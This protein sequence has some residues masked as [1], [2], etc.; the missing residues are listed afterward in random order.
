MRIFNYDPATGEFL[1]EGIADLCPVSKTNWI[2]PAHAT[3]LEPPIVEE[4][5]KACFVNNKWEITPD[6]RGEQ[7]YYL[8]TRLPVI[9]DFIGEIPEGYVKELPIIPITEQEIFSIQL[10]EKINTVNNKLSSVNLLYR[11]I[12][13]GAIEF[14]IKELLSNPTAEMV[15]ETIQVIQY[16]PLPPGLT[17]EQITDINDIK[18]ELI[19]ILEG[20]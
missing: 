11:S 14:C 18:Q 9:I 16:Y 5:Q 3:S 6:L 10:K 8:D 15:Q 13:S 4:K 19:Q 7:Y 1:T 2:I 12:F 17:Q 20:E